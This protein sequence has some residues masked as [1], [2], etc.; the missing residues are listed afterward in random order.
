[1]KNL[2]RQFRQALYNDE[3]NYLVYADITL[4]NN[5]ELN[6]T[7][8]EIWTGGFTYEESVSQDNNFSAL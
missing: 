6:L 8:S 1:M 4:S 7:N 2:S 3:R 5:T